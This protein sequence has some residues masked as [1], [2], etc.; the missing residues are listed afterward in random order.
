[1]SST[2]NTG[3][4]CIEVLIVED[5]PTQAFLLQRLLKKS[6]YTVSVAC[7]GVEALAHLQENIPSLVIS[8]ILMP[9]MDGYELCR[10]IKTQDG[11]KRIPV[12]LLTQLSEPKD[13]IKGLECGADNFVTK[14]YDRLHNLLLK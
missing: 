10:K 11:L 13:I 8:D 9:E 14:P 4:N 6:G 12:M 5:N 3:Q 7:N 2:N 1:M